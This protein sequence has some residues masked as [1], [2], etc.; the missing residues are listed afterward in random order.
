MVS[1][2]RAAGASISP[3]A[4]S[5]AADITIILRLLAG[6]ASEDSIA[7][8]IVDLSRAAGDLYFMHQIIPAPSLMIEFFRFASTLQ[9][10]IDHS[11]ETFHTF[12]SVSIVY[13]SGSR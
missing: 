10:S 6:S 2:E 9:S 1:A 11:R 7:V 4:N 8:S 13:D 3:E 5:R 12:T